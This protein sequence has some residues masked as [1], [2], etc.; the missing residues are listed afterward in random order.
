M[1]WTPTTSP[2]RTPRARRCSGPA[3]T[4]AAWTPRAS[5]TPGRGRSSA[6][7]MRW[8]SQSSTLSCCAELEMSGCPAGKAGRSFLFAQFPTGYYSAL[9][10]CTS[11]RATSPLP[12]RSA[13]PGKPGHRVSGMVRSCIFLDRQFALV[14]STDCVRVGQRATVATGSERPILLKNQLPQQS[15][16]KIS[17]SASDGACCI[18]LAQMGGKMIRSIGQARAESGLMVKSAVYNLGSVRKVLP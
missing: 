5:R 17:V 12:T 3:A 18:D 7:R 4:A 16:G 11:K 15:A 1:G 13:N 10:A 9:P 2:A 8:R 14:M 6:S